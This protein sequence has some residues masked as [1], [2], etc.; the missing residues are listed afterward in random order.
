MVFCIRELGARRR[1]ESDLGRV[2]HEVEQRRHDY[3][4]A[5]AH[6]LRNP[7]SAIVMVSDLLQ[8]EEDPELLRTQLRRVKEQASGMVDLITHY[9]ELS[10]LDAG[11]YPVGRISLDLNALLQERLAEWAG[12]GARKGQTL[13]FEGGE[14]GLS[15]Q[16]DPDACTRVIDQVLD[17]AVKFAPK[18]SRIRAAV[19]RHSDWGEICVWDEGP[20]FK[21]E[22]HRRLFQPCTPLSARPTGG[23]SAVGLGLCIAKRLMDLTGG[24]IEVPVGRGPVKLYWPR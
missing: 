2:K 7:L 14:D 13:F 4:R 6:D 3:L 11:R 22:D 21:E 17:N 23:E 24:R 15:V 20:G 9:V 1:A 16:G 19:Q 18:G 8:E 12:R 10:A 5:F